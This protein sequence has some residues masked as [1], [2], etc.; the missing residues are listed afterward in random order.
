MLIIIKIGTD[1]IICSCHHSI[2]INISSLLSNTL[3]TLV[4]FFATKARLCLCTCCPAP[5]RTSAPAKI[6]HPWITLENSRSQIIKVA[7][8]K[9]IVLI[10]YDAQGIY[11]YF[12]KPQ[13]KMLKFVKPNPN[14]RGNSNLFCIST[15]GLLHYNNS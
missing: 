13:V 11:I 15:C 1:H 14:N 7:K 5:A 8:S 10:V 9:P 4:I 2:P 12:S 6:W 3:V